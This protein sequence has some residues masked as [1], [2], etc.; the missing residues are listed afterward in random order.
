MS[1]VMVTY[2][3]KIWQECDICH[4]HSH[5][6]HGKLRGRSIIANIITI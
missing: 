6:S 4:S 3:T 2:M 1:Y 5:M